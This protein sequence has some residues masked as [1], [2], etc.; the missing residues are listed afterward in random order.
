[1]CA[2]ELRGDQCGRGAAARDAG[3]RAHRRLSLRDAGACGQRRC[4]VQ[5]GA[6]RGAAGRGGG[7]GGG[8]LTAHA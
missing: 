3:G 6:R 5:L 8:A 4:V 2:G 7:R 1:M